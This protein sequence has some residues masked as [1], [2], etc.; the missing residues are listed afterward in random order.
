MFYSL[1][2]VLTLSIVQ[3]VLGKFFAATL[4]VLIAEVL[5]LIY[6]IILCF[7]GTPYIGTAIIALIG[8][9]LLSMA[10]IS[11]GILASSITENQI[12]S[13]II[14][15]S[16]FILTWFLP[17]FGTN[18]G[19]LSLINMFDKFPSGLIAIKEIVAFVTFTIMCILLTIIVMQRRKNVK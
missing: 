7:L 6:Y 12:I 8:F 15:I 18:F 19:A 3:S 17:D 11:F 16:F 5:T 2:T 13:A 1:A 14:T 4:V 10:Y 9:L